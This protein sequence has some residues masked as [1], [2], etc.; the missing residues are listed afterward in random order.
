MTFPHS[1]DA[2]L[3]DIDVHDARVTVEVHLK[4][5]LKYFKI[6]VI[7]SSGSAFIKH[8]NLT[9]I[10]HFKVLIIIGDHI[11]MKDGRTLC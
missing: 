2:D 8:V 5:K 4:I 3:G 11:V 1:F 10:G 7:S 9:P 6:K